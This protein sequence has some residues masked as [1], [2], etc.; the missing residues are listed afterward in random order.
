MYVA[1]LAQPL[2]VEYLLLDPAQYALAKDHPGGLYDFVR[3]TPGLDGD[4]LRFAS[5]AALREHCRANGIEVV[6]DLHG[7]PGEKGTPRTGSGVD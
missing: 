6:G 4:G 7:C 2:S 5:V 3:R 1:A